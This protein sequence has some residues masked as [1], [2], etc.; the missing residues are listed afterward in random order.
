MGCQVQDLAERIGIS[1]A[2]LF[3]YRAGKAKVSDKSWGK[4]ERAEASAGLRKIYQTRPSSAVYIPRVAEMEVSP[5][6]TVEERLARV[7]R[8][9]AE[10]KVFT[11]ALKVG[12][13]LLD[14]EGPAK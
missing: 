9:L 4:L 2:T 10:L 11:R 8:D 6:L 1:R 5:P 13:R 12:L 14:E 7:E 3:A